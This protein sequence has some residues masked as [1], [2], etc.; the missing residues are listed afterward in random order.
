MI[1]AI[2]QARMGSSRFP[3]KVLKD[4]DGQKILKF[5]IER[6]KKSKSIDSI[7]VATTLEDHDDE[8][9]NFC[10]DNKIKFFRGE[11]NDV[12]SRYYQ[13]AKKNNIDTIVRLTADCPLIDPVIIDEVINLFYSESADY[14]SNTVPP[15]SSSWPDG[16]DVEVFSFLALERAHKEATKNEDKEHV[17]F[18]FWKDKNNGFK[19]TQLKNHLDWS[20]YRFTIDYPQDY[21]VVKLLNEEIR[22]R[23]IFGHTHE[24]VSILKQRR[25]IQII[26][27][28]YYFGIG[29]KKEE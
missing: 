3:G 9:E 10:L 20:Q 5:Q 15:S 11:E 1:G 13:C 17:T 4:L 6:I 23:N 18:Y 16:S 7:I 19:T 24:I 12:L 8:I 28:D 29:W 27:Q 22:A 26:N 2:I 21:E 25:D 14:A